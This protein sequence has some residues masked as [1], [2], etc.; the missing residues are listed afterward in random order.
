MFLLHSGQN[1]RD[2]VGRVLQS[3]RA[4][5]TLQHGFNLTAGNI[6]TINHMTHLHY[7]TKQKIVHID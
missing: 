2:E 3:L 6:I 5:H 4:H 7:Y 1:G